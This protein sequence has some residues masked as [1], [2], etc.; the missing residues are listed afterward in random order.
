MSK[1]LYFIWVGLFGNVG[2]LDFTIEKLSSKEDLKKRKGDE[3]TFFGKKNAKMI[4]FLKIWDKLGFSVFFG[5]RRGKIGIS[6]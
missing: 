2:E 5:W 6:L 4:T 3:C 1:L